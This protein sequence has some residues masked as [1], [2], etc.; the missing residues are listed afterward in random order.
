[1]MNVAY[2]DFLMDKNLAE[3][4]EPSQVCPRILESKQSLVDKFVFSGFKALETMC[5][6]PCTEKKLS[7]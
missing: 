6:L 2:Y 1:M 7:P 5:V 3:K 4:L